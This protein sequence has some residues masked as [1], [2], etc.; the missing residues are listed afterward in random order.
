MLLDLSTIFKLINYNQPQLRELDPT[1]IQRI[2]EGAYL[3]K[4]ISETE[5]TARKCDY[6]SL[7]CFDQ[8]LKNFFNSES[9]KLKNAKSKLQQY[10]ESMTKE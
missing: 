7:Q 6:Y 1:T 5:V 10:Y 2:K 8:E 4:I 9:L 3:V